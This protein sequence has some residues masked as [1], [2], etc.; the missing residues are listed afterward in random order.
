M[1]WPVLVR[2]GTES[3]PRSSVFI[4]FN[5]ILSLSVSVQ[6]VKIA[7]CTASQEGE[8]PATPNPIVLNPRKLKCVR[9]RR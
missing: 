1:Y 6:L 3:I 9:E 7:V 2:D 5:F 8:S 4:F